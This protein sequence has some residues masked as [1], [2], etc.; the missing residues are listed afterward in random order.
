MYRCPFCSQ[1]TTAGCMGLADK[2]S[3]NKSSGHAEG[4]V[5]NC[6]ENRPLLNIVRDGGVVVA[7]GPYIVGFFPEYLLHVLHTT[8]IQAPVS[9]PP[10]QFWET[11]FA[12]K[13]EKTKKKKGGS[14]QYPEICLS[15]KK[16]KDQ[17]NAGVEPATLRLR[18]SR[19]AD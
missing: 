16:Q 15:E 14:L 6:S 11:D 10:C 8:Y 3:R 5:G 17:P 2:G 9:T 12:D 19:S 4:R 13:R 1:S 18:V 7:C